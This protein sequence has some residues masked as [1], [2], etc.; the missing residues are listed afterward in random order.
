MTWVPELSPLDTNTA[1]R[2]AMRRK[3]ATPSFMPRTPAGSDPAGSDPAGSAAG[4]R[5]MKSLCM[6]SRRFTP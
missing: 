2:S 1:C 4:P 5:M 3:A 6:T